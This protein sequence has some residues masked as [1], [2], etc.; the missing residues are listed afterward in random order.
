MEDSLIEKKS[1]MTARCKAMLYYMKG[2]MTIMRCTMHTGRWAVI[3]LLVPGSITDNA[4]ARGQRSA[5]SP[6]FL[7]LSPFL[8]GTD[9]KMTAGKTFPSTLDDCAPCQNFALLPFSDPP[10]RPFSFSCSINGRHV[11]CRLTACLAAPHSSPPPTRQKTASLSAWPRPSS[12]PPLPP[13]RLVTAFLWRSRCGRSLAGGEGKSKQSFGSISSRDRT[14]VLPGVFSPCS[15]RTSS[16]VILKEIDSS[17]V[18]MRHSRQSEGVQGGREEL[19][20]SSDSWHLGQLSL[21]TAC[22]PPP[23]RAGPGYT[24]GTVRGERER[25]GGTGR[26]RKP[27]PPPSSRGRGRPGGQPRSRQ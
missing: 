25:E 20:R 10:P 27:P 16:T 7:S 8:N 6:F 5:P 3:D 22:P 14:L 19:V 26:P 23:R 2:T 13:F 17:I 9:L 21:S 4:R 12:S 11:T 1:D 15:H 24:A 18:N